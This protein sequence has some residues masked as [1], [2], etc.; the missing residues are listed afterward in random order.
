MNQQYRDINATID[1]TREEIDAICAAD[2]YDAQ[3]YDRAS[4]ELAA[5]WNERDEM[6]A[7]LLQTQYNVTSFMAGQCTPLTY[8]RALELAR[9]ANAAR[10]NR[11]Y[12]LEV[13]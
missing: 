10:D 12:G 11:A 5:L 13:A 7:F 9:G 4:E 8:A 3:A 1:A 2:W 6:L